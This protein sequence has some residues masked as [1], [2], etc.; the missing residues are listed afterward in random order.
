MAFLKSV[1][2]LLLLALAIVGTVTATAHAHQGNSDYRSV[3]SSITPARLADGLTAQVVNFDD[4][5]VLENRS[6][7]EVE[8]LGYDGE[9]Y[10]RILAD[11]TVEVNLN[12]PTHYKNEDRFANVKIP[13]RA[14]KDAKPDWK[15]VDTDG[16]FEWHDHRSH[17]MGDGVPPQVKDE[18]ERTE[19]FPYTIP[20]RVGG[21]PAQI[22]GTLY[23][24]GRDDEVPVLPFLMLAV[25]AVG[26]GALLLRR[27]RTVRN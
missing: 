12:S 18:S 23:W 7:R 24:Q 1:A 19:I 4:H 26:G 25:L 15:Q 5:V 27:R 3:I 8:I 20:L 22:N 6:G 17:Y 13:A 2:G 9:P 11:G 16:R 10:A 21:E 14:D